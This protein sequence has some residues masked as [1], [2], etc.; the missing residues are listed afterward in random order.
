MN[1]DNH[2]RLIDALVTEGLP[3]DLQARLL[4]GTLRQVRRRR[5]LRHGMRGLAALVILLIGTAAGSF[6]KRAHAPAWHPLAA[7]HQVVAT[8]DSSPV[9]TV[10]TQPLVP[11]VHTSAFPPVPV[12]ATIPRLPV[13]QL[14]SD[15][16]L[17]ALAAPFSPTL[18][19]VGPHQQTLVLAPTPP[20]G[21]SPH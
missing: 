18:V 16:E 21:P 15:S 8:R 4:A 14:L 17:L 5:R 9:P 19:R 6:W 11:I 3:P 13:Y 1:P 10:R 2:Q 7:T 20:D 12:I